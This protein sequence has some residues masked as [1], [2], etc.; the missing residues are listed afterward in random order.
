MDVLRGRVGR[1]T[2]APMT[3]R[4]RVCRKCGRSLPEDGDHFVKD[5]GCPLGITR[6]CHDCRN[7]Y[8]NKWRT[9]PGNAG[10]RSEYH[11]RTYKP[12]DRAA[13]IRRLAE[14]APYKARAEAMR[15]GLLHAAKEGTKVDNDAF[16][17]VRLTEMLRANPRCPCCGR[18]F[19]IGLRFNGMKDDASPTL[20]RFVGARGYVI[21]NVTMICWR[22]NNLKRDA[23]AAELQ[24]VVDWM[25]RRAVELA[26]G[27][28]IPGAE[29]HP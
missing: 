5:K 3:Q 18:E 12:A 16:S 28:Q 29:A 26:P 11:K 17:I 10:K 8:N 14:A 24:L 4:M 27:D 25:R 20:D 9:L 13:K 1:P 19:R 7:K 2:G 23:D 22:C 21:G 6:K 15:R